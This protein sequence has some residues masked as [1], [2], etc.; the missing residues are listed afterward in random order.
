LPSAQNLG[1]G[2]HA[3]KDAFCGVICSTS[4]EVAS[5]RNELTDGPQDHRS[6]QSLGNI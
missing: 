3:G 1:I 5:Q 2:T 6:S 4:G